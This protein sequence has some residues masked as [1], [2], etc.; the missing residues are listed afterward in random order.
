MHIEEG[1]LA[2]SGAG[3][4]LLAGSALVAAAGTA[5]G[6]RRLDYQRVPQVAMLSAAFF[7]ASLI[8]VPLGVGSV[9]LVLNGLLGLILGWA[10]FPAILIALFM[11]A[12]FLGFGGLTTLGI[13][14]CSMALPALAVHYLLRRAVRAAPDGVAL[15][16]GLAAGALAVLASLG[17]WATAMIVAQPA[18]R[19]LSQAMVVAH[20]GLALIEGLITASAVVF[21]RKV[22]PELLQSPVVSFRPEGSDA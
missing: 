3:L 6:L 11:Q 12:V 19:T 17:L 22:R 9:H 1:V 4:G 10:A 8:H 7:V 21:L 20:A 16:G 14:T 5:I 15:A 13:N 2:A 18:F